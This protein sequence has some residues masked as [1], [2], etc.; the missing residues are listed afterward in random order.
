MNQIETQ[1]N[2]IADYLMLGL[3]LDPKQAWE[4]FGCSK[5]STRSG[6]LLRE[7]RIPKL[8]KGWKEVEVLGRKTKVRTY[9]VPSVKFEDYKQQTK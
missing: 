8:L 1:K 2:R 6:E 4:M 7:G 5:I 9:R 3:E